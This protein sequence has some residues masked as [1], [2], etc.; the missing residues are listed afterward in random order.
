MRRIIGLVLIGVGMFLLVLAP[1]ARFYAYPRLA[2][3]PYDQNTLTVLD[4]PNATVFDIASLKEIQTDLTTTAKT[5]G[6]IGGSEKAPEGDTV[7]VTTSSTRD[8]T[9]AVR[10][11]SIERA[12]FLWSFSSLAKS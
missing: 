2:V 1:L 7:W 6:D 11:R 9:G 12:A 5:I 10:S 4:G 8:S 3:A